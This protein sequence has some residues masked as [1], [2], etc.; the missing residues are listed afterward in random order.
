MKLLIAVFSLAMLFPLW[1][2]EAQP[3]IKGQL[4]MLLAEI[5][6]DLQQANRNQGLEVVEHIA[7][8]TNIMR[9]KA[10]QINLIT[11]IMVGKYR[12]LRS[13]H[14][15]AQ[16]MDRQIGSY[17]SAREA[18]EG[19]GTP[20]KWAREKRKK[21]DLLRF[22][23]NSGFIG[24]NYQGIEDLEDQLNHI[25]WDSPQADRQF[26]FEGMARGLDRIAN[27]QYDMH[28]LQ[29]AG[30]LHAYRAQ[31]RSFTHQVAGL[32]AFF[33]TTARSCPHDGDRRDPKS[34][35]NKCEI[36]SCV[37]QQIN[38]TRSRL[39]DIKDLGEKYE[40]MNPPRHLS[41]EELAPAVEIHA[42]NVE[43]EIIESA[44][45]QLRNCR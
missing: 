42:F 23:E 15:M 3:E 11:G 12:D 45:R 41:E 38:H 26:V 22:L 37:Y 35:G 21:A 18:A 5:D 13:F 7:W 20:E 19:V 2:Q 33:D 39:G 30:G 40:N 6:K 32:R 8:T 31:T 34:D 4:E 27:T 29:G 10:K 44:A 28:Q 16:A 36:S 9:T 24:Q 25:N 1:A 14:R 43:N 17:R